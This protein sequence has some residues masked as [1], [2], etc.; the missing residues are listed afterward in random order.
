MGTGE[1]YR[2]EGDRC[3]PRAR[4]LFRTYVAPNEGKVLRRKHERRGLGLLQ[5]CLCTVSSLHYGQSRF[6]RD[7][8]RAA[9]R[10]EREPYRL[11]LLSPRRRA[12]RVTR[13]ILRSKLPRSRSEDRRTDSESATA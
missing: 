2:R 5:G 1:V 4:L 12:D 7:D 11:S 8:E 3:G 10:A 13:T 9:G 6:C